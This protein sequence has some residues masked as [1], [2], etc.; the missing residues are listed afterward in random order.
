MLYS[1]IHEWLLKENIKNEKGERIEFDNH[2]FLFD[3]Y[4]DQ[5]QYLTVMKAAQIGMST[6]A[7]LKNHNDARNQ[8][9]DIIYS[10]PPRRC[11]E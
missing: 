3:I 6:V 1:D 7:I 10:L 9:I 5:S 8:K 2:P 11:S 4:K